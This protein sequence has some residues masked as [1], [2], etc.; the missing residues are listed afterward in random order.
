MVKC[1]ASLSCALPTS[2][3]AQSS[4]WERILLGRKIS[5][6]RIQRVGGVVQC[7][8]VE[9]E[10]ATGDGAV[11]KEGLQRTIHSNWGIGSG[12]QSSVPLEIFP[13][14]S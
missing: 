3:T 8:G 12:F 6:Q 13:P 9:K 1:S 11:G 5:K 2:T 10:E 7:H 14:L 4:I